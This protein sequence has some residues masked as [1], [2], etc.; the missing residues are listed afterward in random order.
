MKTFKHLHVPETWEHYWTRYPEGYSILEALISWVAQVDKM[1]DSQN[2]LMVNVNDFRKKIDDFINTFEVNLQDKVTEILREW[3]DS[4]FLDVV[5]NEAIE[6]RLS[7]LIEELKER[8]YDIRYHSDLVVDGDWTPAINKTIDELEN[9]GGGTVLI[10]NGTYDYYDDIVFPPGVGVTGAT[11]EST[12]RA[13]ARNVT[14]VFEG[15][16]SINNLIVDGNDVTGWLLRIKGS[17]TNITNNTFKN[18][19]GDKTTENTVGVMIEK[20]AF[21]CVVDSNDFRNLSAYQDNIEGNLIGAVRGVWSRGK[22]TTIKNNRFHD[23]EYGEDSDYVYLSGDL[24]PYGEYPFTENPLTNGYYSELYSVV[25]NNVFY[26]SSKSPIKIQASACSIANNTIYCIEG[27]TGYAFRTYSSRENIFK[28]NYI[29]LSNSEFLRDVVQV[30][31]TQNTTL[32]NNVIQTRKTY[33]VGEEPPTLSTL[34][35]FIYNVGLTFKN[36][37]LELP[38]YKVGVCFYVSGNVS[39]LVDSNSVT[40]GDVE[41]QFQTNSDPIEGLTISKNHFVFNKLRYPMLIS[42]AAKNNR[43]FSFMSN[44]YSV[45]SNYSTGSVGFFIRGV[46]GFIFKNNDIYI[47]N[48]FDITIDN[49][50]NAYVVDNIF[51]CRININKDSSAVKISK[52][53]F[54]KSYTAIIGITTIEGQ[55]PSGIT[56]DNNTVD[57]SN[58]FTSIN[59]GG[60]KKEIN[61]FSNNIIKWT[62]ENNYIVYVD[63][64]SE[65]TQNMGEI[66]LQN[67]SKSRKI[68]YG[69]SGERPN[70][71]KYP[72]YQYYD[73][74]YNLLIVWDGNEWI[75]SDGTNIE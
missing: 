2:E 3:Q 21:N 36:N 61:I 55:S 20:N 69:F 15:K 18:V 49:T 52:N 5:I 74:S 70:F 38:Q 75:K 45:K 39:L 44:K 71:N 37:T 6:T 16:Q 7:E 12:L 68:D 1:V 17:Q 35:N 60:N 31:Y 33:G 13:M 48:G 9:I 40:M 28:D 22:Y 43:Q 29:Y 10:P 54:T 30:Q 65:S 14:L 73:M 25:E 62:T 42:N 56:I 26:G 4:G 53:S 50:N 51:N 8:Q 11:R 58:I 19:Y 63:S 57:E 23:M 72:G 24:M 67:N 46:S 66:S 34:C 59:G 47:P 32:D 64:E 27:F 41:Q